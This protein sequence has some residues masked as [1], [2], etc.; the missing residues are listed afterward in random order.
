M[1]FFSS[2]GF[3]P[4]FH[5]QQIEGKKVSLKKTGPATGKISNFAHFRCTA[6]AVYP[7]KARC[8][9][10]GDCLSAL[11]TFWVVVIAKSISP[12]LLRSAS[13]DT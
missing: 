1:L 5:N 8:R 3:S 13:T 2:R 9:K 6:L 7:D 10:T 4:F 12:R 11:A